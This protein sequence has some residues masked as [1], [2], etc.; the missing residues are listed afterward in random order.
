MPTVSTAH[1]TVPH[2]TACWP[3]TAWRTSI[4]DSHTDRTAGV[5][6]VVVH[7]VAA[8]VRVHM[9]ACSTHMIDWCQL[10]LLRRAWECL[11]AQGRMHVVR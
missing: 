3:G 4:P 6:A 7:P 10:C 9:P 11:T 2:T 1:G 8:L 5:H